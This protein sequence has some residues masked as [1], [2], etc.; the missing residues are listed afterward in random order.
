MSTLYDARI[1]EAPKLPKILENLEIGFK[2]GEKSLPR[3]HHEELEKAFPHLFGL[4]KLT[5]HA[6]GETFSMCFWSDMEGN[7]LQIIS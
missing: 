1:Q 3:A 5:A 7:I 2:E 6:G 4:P